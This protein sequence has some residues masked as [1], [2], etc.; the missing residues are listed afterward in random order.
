MM[1]RILTLT[2]VLALC[3]ALALPVLAAESLLVVDDGDLLS[4]G[5]E[6]EL[7][8]CLESIREKHGC[9]VAV[10]TLQTTDGVDIET[11]AE[12]YQARFGLDEDCV[13]LVICMEDRS[14]DMSVYGRLEQSFP[15]RVRER[16]AE[17]FLEYLSRGDY[18][19]AFRIYAD[20]CDAQLS[21]TNSGWD[22]DTSGRL[23]FGTGTLIALGIGLA[24]AGVTTGVMAAQLKS[25]ALKGAAADY[26]RPGSL[27]LT[28]QQDIFLYHQVTKRPKPQNNGGGSG[29]SSHGNHTG[30]HF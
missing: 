22:A 27:K 20:E 29:G 12:R 18:Y 28:R 23:S 7:T 30:G 16:I 15:G 14:W 19:K 6:R 11:Y 17:E 8:A 21:A 10:L 9:D 25:V 5:E 4:V 24:A 26:V 2:A 13:L 3:F 1:K